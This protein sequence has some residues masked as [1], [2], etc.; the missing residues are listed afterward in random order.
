[1]ELL[2]TLNCVG[3]LGVICITLALYYCWNNDENPS[4]KRW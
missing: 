4:V 2:A 1:M 3:A